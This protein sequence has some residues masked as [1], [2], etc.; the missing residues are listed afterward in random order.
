M[1]NTYSYPTNNEL[2]QIERSLLP[3]L[4][5]NDAIFD[6]MPVRNVNAAYV[7]WEQ[8][9]DF[10]GL[11][12]VRGING[13]PGVVASRGGKRFVLTPG[14]YGEKA[15]LDEQQITERR[16]YGDF[17]GAINLTD[18]VRE[19]QDQLLTREINLRRY[20]GWK[21]LSSGTFSIAAANGAVMHTDTF[22]LATYAGSQWTVAGNDTPLADFRGAKLLQRGKSV[23]FGSQARAFMN[24]TMV[25]RLLGNTNAADLGGRRTGGGNTFNSVRDIN[26]I[27]LDQDLPQVVP[28]DEGYLDDSGTFQLFIPNNKI[29]VV[30]RRTDGGRIMEYQMTRNANNPNEAPGSYVKVVDK[31]DDVPRTVEVHRG[32]NGGPAVLYPSAICIITT[33]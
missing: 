30:G 6:I 21:L 17:G 13:Q 31:V 4:E 33:T 25:N 28:Y 19:R 24:S 9:D 15:L 12:Q 26:N 7:S 1:P 10:V 5:E 16:G 27:L 22:A 23:N 8:Q 20:I 3:V 29:V 11:Q 32:H 18:L 2:R 14:V